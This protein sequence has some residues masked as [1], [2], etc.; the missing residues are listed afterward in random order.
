MS[1]TRQKTELVGVR[2][3]P[4][5]HTAAIGLAEE[6]DVSVPELLRQLLAMEIDRREPFL[7]TETGAAFVARLKQ[8]P[9]WLLI[10]AAAEDMYEAANESDEGPGGGMWYH[11]SLAEPAV[12][13]VMRELTESGRLLVPTAEPCSCDGRRWVDDEGWSPDPGERA[14]VRRPG[15][16]LVPCGFCNHGGWSVD[17]WAVDDD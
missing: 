13:A 10:E 9:H 7:S 5:E 15:A 4:D 6:R 1:E 14:E 2:L 16:G 8:H 3:E 17:E 11:L 12:D